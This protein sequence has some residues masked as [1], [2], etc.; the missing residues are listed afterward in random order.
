[1][2][3]ER[4]VVGNEPEDD[5]SVLIFRDFQV[6]ALIEGFV[7]AEMPN[8]DADTAI[9]LYSELK[10]ILARSTVF[11]TIYNVSECYWAVSDNE[12]KQIEATETMR[13]MVAAI[14]QTMDK[15]DE[16]F[17]VWALTVGKALQA[18]LNRPLS[19]YVLFIKW[20]DFE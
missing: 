12:S 10:A 1:M 11:D 19:Y 6:L 13:E 14:A 18:T 4:I 17:Q 5:K 2:K 8:I 7:V 9:D 16:T 15:E 3:R 20:C